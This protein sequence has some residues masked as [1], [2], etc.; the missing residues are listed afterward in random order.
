MCK[1]VKLYVQEGPAATPAPPGQVRLFSVIE[2]YSGKIE[3][4]FEI[5]LVR[6]KMLLFG[7]ESKFRYR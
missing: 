4:Q 3:C 7:R 6:Y 2:N 5:L 1:S